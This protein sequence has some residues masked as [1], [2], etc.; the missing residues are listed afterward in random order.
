M[1]LVQVVSLDI[2]GDPRE[3][4]RGP[5]QARG[6]KLCPVMNGLDGDG[7]LAPRRMAT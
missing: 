2:H 4:L 1:C 6:P 3:I 7:Y 5:E